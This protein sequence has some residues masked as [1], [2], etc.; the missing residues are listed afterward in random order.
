[1]NQT[2]LTIKHS[3]LKDLYNKI[4]TFSCSDL[5]LYSN[6]KYEIAVEIGYSMP[7]YQN[8]YREIEDSTNGLK[9]TI[10]R[11][12]I[13]YCMFLIIK[14]LESRPI[15]NGKGFPIRFLRA[16]EVGQ[17][18]EGN[19]EISLHSL[20]SG[21]V[22]EVSLKIESTNGKPIAISN[23][24]KYKTSFAFDFMYRSNSSL[25]EF[26]N[27]ENV[28]HLGASM[29]EKMD[30]SQMD[31]PPF[32]EYI[33]DVVDYYRLAI[34]SKDSYIK[35]LS[36][37]HT[38]EYFFDEVFKNKMVFDLRDKITHPDFSYKND[39]NLYDIAKFVHNRWRMDDEAG[40]GNELESFKFVLSEYVP[41][42]ELMDKINAI[43]SSSIDYYKENKVS[44]CDAP[45]IK[46]TDMQGIITLI[47]QRI[48]YTR[49]AL[50]HSKSG[51]NKQRYRPYQ[52]EKI[53]QKEIPLV[54]AV[55]ELVIINSSKIF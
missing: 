5:E 51:K 23:F 22:G 11:P 16:V 2:N 43:N 26:S 4:S 36:F 8:F 34:E 42:R 10:G 33:A 6:I 13:E 52:D 47:A 24:R 53:L 12:T 21:V 41:I 25:V 18:Y 40:Q 31:N 46:W 39:E 3:D 32:R 9:Y 55:A 28:F 19:G 20:L 29:R 30:I 45:C 27:I 7:H 48:Y 37:Y 35:Y 38:I 1:M 50:V 14:Y 17:I 49:N 15:V 54:K 44:F